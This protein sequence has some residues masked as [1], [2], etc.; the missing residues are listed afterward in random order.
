[1]K[2]KFKIGQYSVKTNYKG[3]LI[4]Q[5]CLTFLMNLGFASKMILGCRPNMDIILKKTFVMKTYTIAESWFG[6]H[7][8]RMVILFDTGG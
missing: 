4:S 3:K 2:N 5:K 1:M 8:Q 6:S 7:R